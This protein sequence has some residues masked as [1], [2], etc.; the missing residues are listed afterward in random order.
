MPNLPK[1]WI[2]HR[3]MKRRCGKD[4][5]ARLLVKKVIPYTKYSKNIVLDTKAFLLRQP[6]VRIPSAD[7][8]L[9]SGCIPMTS[10]C[11]PFCV[12][13]RPLTFIVPRSSFT[14][15]RSPF[16]VHRSPFT[17]HRSPLNYV[18]RLIFDDGTIHRERW[19]HLDDSGMP[20]DGTR[21]ECERWVDAKGTR[22]YDTCQ[23][24]FFFSNVKLGK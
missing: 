13:L 12:Q 3:S 18:I 4:T 17:V 7:V 24:R 11:V 10:G 19:T 1:A 2:I 22:S 14:V 8:P 16:T 15:H 21:M 5:S 23:E 20:P 6:V 9:T